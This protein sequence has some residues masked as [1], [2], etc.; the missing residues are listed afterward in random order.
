MKQS[1]D[2]ARTEDINGYV[3]IKDNPISKAGVFPYYGRS[4]G[5]DY[6]ADQ[7]YQVYRPEE[8]LSDPL[9]AESFRLIPWI[10]DHVMLGAESSGLT[11]PEK[12]GV[13]GVI[14]EN[15][16][17]RDGTLYGNL[18]LF[19]ENLG[20]MIES[21]EKKELSCGYRCRYEKSSGVW[22]GQRYD[23]IQRSIRGNHLA[24]VSEGRMGPEVAVLDHLNFTFDTREIAMADKSKEEMEKEKEAADKMAKDRAMKDAKDAEEKAEKEKSDKEAADRK[25]KDEEEKAKSDK[26]KGEGTDAAIKQ[27]QTALDGALKTISAQSKQIEDLTKNG[28]KSVVT[29]VASRDALANKLSNFVGSFDH[30]EMT[31]SEVGKYGV[32]KLG[33]QCA[34]GQELTALNGYLHNRNAPSKSASMAMDSVPSDELEAY[35]NP[36]KA[37]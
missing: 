4:L 8:E 21:G 32:T 30:R 2:S 33:L 25:A 28:M 17:Y 19:S 1:M 27:M 29:E 3:E 7:V 14:G 16:Y 20:E 35:L 18:K 22:N 5:K 34:E 13:S 23:A 9:C 11:P 36:T 12:K 6:I 31:L 15:V 37:A 10:E 24:S 26:E